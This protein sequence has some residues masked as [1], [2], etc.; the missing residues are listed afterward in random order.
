M[1][2]GSRLEDETSPP[3]RIGCT[4]NV[5]SMRPSGLS[6]GLNATRPPVNLR[7]VPSVNARGASG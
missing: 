3:A 6:W 4:V 1:R 2:P 7:A 5:A